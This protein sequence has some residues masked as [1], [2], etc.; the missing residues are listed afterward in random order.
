M[1]RSMRLR[2]QPL[3]SQTLV[4]PLLFEFLRVLQKSEFSLDIL[5]DQ[6]RVF[7][8]NDDSRA[9]KPRK[10]D[11]I[12]TESLFLCPALH[13]PQNITQTKKIRPDQ[14]GT[15]VIT[16]FLPNIT[17]TKKMVINKYVCMIINKYVVLSYI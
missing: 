5:I 9:R 17:Q 10:S 14:N 1:W 13:V 2:E 8:D 15:T 12:K 7:K 3:T 11:L 4:P 16:P 6:K